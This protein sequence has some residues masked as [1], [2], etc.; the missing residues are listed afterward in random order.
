MNFKKNAICSQSGNTFFKEQ[1]L[2]ENIFGEIHKVIDNQGEEYIL[3]SINKSKLTNKQK[4]NIIREN[5]IMK[6]IDNPRILKLFEVIE[7]K[8]FIY[9]ITEYC[10]EGNLFDIIENKKGLEEKKANNFLKEISEAFLTTKKLNITHGNLDLYN[11]YLKNG[12][13]VIG[14]FGFIKICKDNFDNFEDN[15]DKLNFIAP[16]ILNGEDCCAKNDIWS[17][18]V[19]Y[20]Y[21][22]FGIMPFLFNNK[23]DLMK[24]QKLFSGKKLKFPKK[25]SFETENLLKKMI[26]FDKEKRIPFKEFFEHHVIKKNEKQENKINLKMNRSEEIKK[27]HKNILKTSERGMK[28]KEN[29]IKNIKLDSNID[30]KEFFNSLTSSLESQLLS[31]SQSHSSISNSD[32]KIT[33]STSP[34]NLKPY[35]YY[36]NLII[37]LIDTIKKIKSCEENEKCLKEFKSILLLNEILLVKKAINFNHFIKENMEKKNNLFK[38]DNFKKISNSKHYS[39]L[40]NFFN[41]F[42]EF[43]GELFSTLNF[44]LENNKDDLI[45][46]KNINYLKNDE[47]NKNIKNFLKKIIIKFLEV[48]SNIDKENQQILMQTVMYIFF[49]HQIIVKCP[50]EKFIDT[51]K[52]QAFCQF[53]EKKNSDLI[54]QKMISFF[55]IQIN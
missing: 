43:I 16:E 49:C 50:Y 54:L 15:F 9:L 21:M 46:L 48:G 2:E 30:K 37:F 13:I 10:L 53:L 55:K 35:L 32:L 38:I 7:E 8:K 26:E 31:F 29:K 33:E 18:G 45:D 41:D 3:K 34:E 19:I 6:N 22:I 14:D 17:L 40:I 42:E 12:D 51:S 24:N 52:W 47:L 27:N 11:I 5:T 4:I 44:F 28:K 36:K 39:Y 20:F 1:K 23:N 25:I